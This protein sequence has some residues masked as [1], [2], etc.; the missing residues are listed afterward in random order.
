MVRPSIE[1][2]RRV[3]SELLFAMPAA[4]VYEICRLIPIGKVTTYGQAA[5]RKDFVVAEAD[6][7]GSAG[8]IAKLAGHP[9]RA[10]GPT[11]RGR[12][13]A[14]DASCSPLRAAALRGLCYSATCRLPHGRCGAQ[15]PGRP[16]R[17]VAAS[18]CVKRRHLG[19]W[20]W[21]RS[22]CTAG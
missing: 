15:V 21:W 8:H 20:R 2:V 18:D 14:A 1:R 3:D 9:S 11:C 19:P 10:W 7:A 22:C 17:T 5:V 12:M 4:R 13:C 6:D 16:F